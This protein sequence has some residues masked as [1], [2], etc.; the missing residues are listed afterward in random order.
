MST[1][2]DKDFE[3]FYTKAEELDKEAR[4]HHGVDMPFC[5]LSKDG[6]LSIVGIVSEGKSPMDS[7][8]PL[9]A[10]FGAQMYFFAAESWLAKSNNVSEEMLAKLKAGELR[11]S[12]L[13]ESMRDE[14]VIMV[15][16]SIYGHKKMKTFNIVRDKNKK[17][18]ALEEIKDMKDFQSSKLPGVDRNETITGKCTICK[19]DVKATNFLQHFKDHHPEE[20][21]E[22][23]EKV[24]AMAGHFGIPK[25]EVVKVV[26][27]LLAKQANTI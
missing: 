26:E 14:A 11:V 16:G 10:K 7:L 1:I 3:E 25:E 12:Q 22:I 2:T 15:G 9:V 18:K 17:I 6:K 4:L 23:V 13:P 20:H 21:K 27:K 5:I 19:T 24:T 8:K